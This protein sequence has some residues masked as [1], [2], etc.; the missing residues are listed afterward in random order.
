M[1]DFR[2]LHKWGEMQKDQSVESTH[3]YCDMIEEK[4]TTMFENLNVT[5]HVE[6][7]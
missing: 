3:Q 7:S 5:I 2:H 6:P 1:T 4:L